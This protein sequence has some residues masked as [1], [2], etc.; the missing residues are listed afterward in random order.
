MHKPQQM[1]LM[2]V[3]GHVR[4]QDLVTVE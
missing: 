3:L 1:E 4:H 2:P